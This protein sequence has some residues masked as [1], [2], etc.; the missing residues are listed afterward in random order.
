MVRLVGALC[1][2][3]VAALQMNPAQAQLQKRE[4]RF[5][6]WQIEM[7]AHVSQVPDRFVDYSCGTGG[8][9]PSTQL[10]SFADFMR[11]RP[12]PSG[13][14][15]VYFRYD[16]ELEYW[17]RAMELEREI[18]VYR[19]TQMYDYPV[20]VSV[21]I[22][23]D[24]YVR[25]RRVVA[26]QRYPEIRE[27]FELWTLG[28][29]LVQRFTRADWTCVDQE[30]EEG[31][32]PVGPDFVKLRC[33]KVKDGL[34]F[35]SEQRYFRKKGQ[36]GIDPHTGKLEVLAFTSTARFEMYMDPWGERAGL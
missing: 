32:T 28:N 19:G 17:A 11:C 22:D 33:T 34:R 35:L 4:R 9:A 30:P 10:K 14:R 26:D 36:M 31:E 13:L 15:E 5:D 16:D 6:I 21:L 2:L 3:T 25:G 7:G 20:I 18:N 27:R 8:N 24:G 23:P 29:F 1:L 12:E